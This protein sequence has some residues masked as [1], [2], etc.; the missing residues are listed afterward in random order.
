MTMAESLAGITFR[1]AAALGLTDRGI[2]KEGL[3]ADIIGF[4]TADYRDILY[5]QGS[6]KPSSVW[7]RGDL[8]RECD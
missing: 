8:V 4:P 1:S 5:N 3:L 2:L 6:L 7:K